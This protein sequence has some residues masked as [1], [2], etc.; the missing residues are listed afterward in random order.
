[1]ST[2]KRLRP[3]QPALQPSCP[4][5]RSSADSPTFSASGIMPRIVAVPPRRSTLTAVAADCGAPDRLDRVVD[6]AAGRVSTTSSAAVSLSASIAVRR[7]Q[8]LGERALLRHRIDR[9]DLARARDLRGVD[10]GQPDPAAADHAHRLARRHVGGVEHRARPRRHRAAEQRGAVERHVA[11]DRDAGMLVD[12]HHLGIGAKVEH[13]RDRPVAEHQ[14][15]RRALRRAR[16]AA[17]MHS[18]MRPVTQNSQWP[19]N[20]REAGDDMVA[21]LDRAHLAADRLD[22]ARRLVP[23]DRRQRV[24]IGAVDEVEVGAAHADRRRCGS[25]PR[26]RPGLSTATSSM[27]SGVLASKRTAAF[28][29]ISAIVTPA[30]AGARRRASLARRTRHAPG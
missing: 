5:S 3:H 16:I 1:M 11:V 7:A 21:D 24:R 30:N 2:G 23:G 19:Q 29:S 12:Q 4:T 27:L 22:H 28:M 8:L 20:A 10:R 13:L 15:R 17:S 26:A 18:D 9:D 6:A 14:P 25:A